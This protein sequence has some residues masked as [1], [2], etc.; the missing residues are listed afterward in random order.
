MDDIYNLHYINSKV[1]W[2][3][4]YMDYGVR[5]QYI[6]RP[7]KIFKNKTENDKVT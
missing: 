6:C 5:S 1:I 2:Q 7:D 4:S 3:L